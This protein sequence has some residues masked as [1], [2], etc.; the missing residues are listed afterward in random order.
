MPI[1]VYCAAPELSS[2]VNYLNEHY[3]DGGMFEIADVAQDGDICFS[4]KEK[5]DEFRGPVA[6]IARGSE[7]EAYFAVQQLL[8]QGVLLPVPEVVPRIKSMIDDF[9]RGWDRLVKGKAIP[10][11]CPRHTEDFAGLVDAKVFALFHDHVEKCL[12]ELARRLKQ[13][14]K[15]IARKRDTYYSLYPRVPASE[16]VYG[17]LVR[18]SEAHTEKVE[19]LREAFE[20]EG[21]SL[22][23]ANLA[24]SQMNV[25]MPFFGGFNRAAQKFTPPSK[26][27]GEN[28]RLVA[29]FMVA[30]LR[31]YLRTVDDVSQVSTRATVKVDSFQG[32]PTMSAN[33]LDLQACWLYMGMHPKGIF[34]FEDFTFPTVIGFRLSDPG[35]SRVGDRVV[36]KRRR[37]FFLERTGKVGLDRVLDGDDFPE[38]PHWGARVRHVDNPSALQNNAFAPIISYMSDHKGESYKLL[39]QQDEHYMKIR[40]P[41]SAE[42]EDFWTRAYNAGV[43]WVREACE[44]LN[45]TSAKALVDHLI[46]VGEYPCAGDVENFDGNTTW[47]VASVFYKELLP[48]RLLRLLERQWNSPAVGTYTDGEGQELWYVIDKSD[49]A[50]AQAADHF[51]SGQQ[52]TSVGGRG[53]MTSLL[54]EFDQ[55][56][57]P[58]IAKQLF[59]GEDDE[60]QPFLYSC[61]EGGDDHK[62]YFAAYYLMT[63]VHPAKLR[64]RYLAVQNAC[65][66]Y[67]ISPEDPPMACGYMSHLDSE[68][69]LL[70]ESLS[71]Q[72]MAGNTIFPEYSKSALGLFASLD[73]YCALAVGTPDEHRTAAVAE[74]IKSDLYGFNDELALMA[75]GEDEYQIAQEAANGGAAQLLIA[76][77]L[78]VSPSKLDYH[79]S[80][81]ALVDLGIPEDLLALWRQPIPR[82]L[83]RD[84]SRFFNEGILS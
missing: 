31:D 69:R 60:F 74:L 72:R 22:S 39:Y 57:F 45:L 4:Y 26:G 76:E 6:V 49:A 50:T 83:S 10:Y 28:A 70:A 71:A 55:A 61:A 27:F 54:L 3:N 23:P 78:G 65:T 52:L 41:G 5:V 30:G 20:A 32:A 47:E 35:S 9:T 84:P 56:A 19:S 43:L 73:H 58:E 63:G 2:C 7:N 68:G 11:S 81:D 64:D 59:N 53:V 67:K 48:E 8:A 24:Y 29:R 75:Q 1:K 33:H 36:A 12:P 40:V 13:R 77:M 79:Y 17:H 82:E 37:T 51:N 66:T 38:D 15:R 21:V 14:G 42:H 44:R 46:E 25:G 16:S 80:W 34:A 62:R 18:E